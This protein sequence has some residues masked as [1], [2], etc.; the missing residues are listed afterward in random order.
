MFTFRERRK[1]SAGNYSISVV[2]TIYGN[3]FSDANGFI[4]PTSEVKQ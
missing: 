3:A 1:S 2:K 4:N